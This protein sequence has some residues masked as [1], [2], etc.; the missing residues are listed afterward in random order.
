MEF[1]FTKIVDFINSTGTNKLKIIRQAIEVLETDY[2]VVKDY[3]KEIREHIIQYLKNPEEK[4]AIPNKWSSEVVKEKLFIDLAQKIKKS[5]SPKKIKWID[6]IHNELINI[7]QVDINVN[8][9]IFAEYNGIKYIIKLYFKDDVLN[10][11]SAELLILMLKKAYEEKYKDF[12][13]RIYDLR[14]NKIYSSDKLKIDDDTE[15]TLNEEIK[16][17]KRYFDRIQES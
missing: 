12:V 10:K 16:L 15:F 13:F 5:F 7:E 1:S 9:E 6:N 3:Y 11:K 17:L 2:S 4:I 14:R 8:P